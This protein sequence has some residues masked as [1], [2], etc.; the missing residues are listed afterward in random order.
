V[1]TESGPGTRFFAERLGTTPEEL[2]DDPNALVRIVHESGREVV[3]LLRR[4]ASTDPA[5]R[6]AARRELDALREHVLAAEEEAD[7]ASGERFRR[8]L[9]EILR[10][11][12]ER[13][14]TAAEQAR[15]D[16]TKRAD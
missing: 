13:L 6:E 16:E 3:D 4:S 9:N 7:T 14:E 8:R 2:A 11:L 1:T 12:V 5:E 15:R 10:N